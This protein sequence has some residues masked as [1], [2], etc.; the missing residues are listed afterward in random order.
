MEEVVTHTELDTLEDLL[1][2]TYNNTMGLYDEN[3]VDAVRAT[4]PESR[5]QIADLSEDEA[6]ELAWDLVQE[7]KLMRSAAI[8]RL[9]LI[10]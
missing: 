7:V 5:L 6:L 10:Q 2:R 8:N 4:I 3:D 9:R 1:A